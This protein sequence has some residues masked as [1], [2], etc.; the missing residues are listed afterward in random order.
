[1]KSVYQNITHVSMVHKP[2]NIRQTSI[3]FS[4]SWSL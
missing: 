2:P 4:L 3:F 1:M